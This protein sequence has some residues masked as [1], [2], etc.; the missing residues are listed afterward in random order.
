M[1]RRLIVEYR[2]LIERIVSSLNSA[3]LE[4]G[5]KIAAAAREIGGY[6]PVKEASVQ[7]YQAELKT[8]LE[9]FNNPVTAYAKPE[10]MK[11]RQL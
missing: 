11:V 1:E 4:T 2:D 6:G 8:L 9:A 10:K 3:N 7:R 5:I